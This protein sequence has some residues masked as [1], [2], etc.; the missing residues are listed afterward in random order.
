[1]LVSLRQGLGKI[2]FLQ[3]VAKK[4]SEKLFEGVAVQKGNAITGPIASGRIPR[5]FWRR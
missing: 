1:M 2:M 5:G 3:D 4:K